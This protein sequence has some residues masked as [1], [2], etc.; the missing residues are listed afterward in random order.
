MKAPPASVDE[1]DLLT[2]ATLETLPQP[3]WE[4]HYG[5]WTVVGDGLD[6]VRETALFLSIP[7]PG[8]R[9]FR[10][11]LDVTDLDKAG[12]LAECSGYAF[13]TGQ[14]A[15]PNLANDPGPVLRISMNNWPIVTTGRNAVTGGRSQLVF[16]RLGGRVQVRMNNTLIL[17][18]KDP[19]PEV[20][21]IDLMLTFSAGLRIHNI[22]IGGD[23]QGQLHSRLAPAKDYELHAC[24]D[25]YDDLVKNPWSERTFCETMQIYRKNQIRRAYFIDHFG[26]TNGFWDESPWTRRF[27][28]FFEHIQKTYENVGEFMP[29]AVRAAHAAGL[30]CY[31]VMKPHDTAFPA[32]VSEG[33]IAASRFGKIHRPGGPQVVS[34]HFTTA[35][36]EFRVEHRTRGLG[37]ETSFHEIS[38]LCLTR[39]ASLPGNFDPSRI[40]IWVSPDNTKYRL[41]NITPRITAEGDTIRLSHLAIREKFFALT[42]IGEPTHTFGNQLRKL[43]SAQDSHGK[44]L[45]LIHACFERSVINHEGYKDWRDDGFA[46]DLP[47]NAF[48]ALDDYFWVDGTSPVAC[49]IGVIQHLPGALCP[50]YSPVTAWWIKLIDQYI[51]AGVDGIDFRI[52][53]HNRT[54][55]W[56][57]YGFNAPI[58]DAFY[59]RYGVDILREPFDRKAWREI[60]G[61]FYTNFLRE[62]SA[63]LKSAGKRVQA[64]VRGDMQSPD[65]H[66]WKETH[67]DWQTWI[68]EGILD[69]LTIMHQSL[70]TAPVKEMAEVAKK[71]GVKVHFRPYLNALARLADGP[72]RLGHLVE[73]TRRGGADGLIL[74][75]N[76]AFLA[77]REDGSVETICPWILECA[78]ET[79]RPL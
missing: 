18:A 19:R 74:Y 30:T 60:R 66:T 72:Q 32:T 42:V 4:T 47:G 6:V 70:R 63:R 16:L 5:E 59:A 26:F 61:E 28:A 29:A 36:P 76:A 1:T 54:F 21:I 48:G 7:T 22:S 10:I 17:D 62:A 13:N 40:R 11:T 57:S 58:V 49:G 38:A 25:F 73:E 53:S 51:A 52:G 39:E 78:R 55:D 33:T 46:M 56:E 3:P 65:W 79:A 2:L 67:Y 24:I 50:A 31:A 27:P 15:A 43:L 34:N 12:V 35:H 37:G 20:R 14:S 71:V 23:Q 64:H 45:P 77:A 9:D 75:E 68:Q 69:E 44:D 8:Q 41:L